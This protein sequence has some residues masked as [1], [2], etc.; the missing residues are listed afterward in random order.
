MAEIPCVAN[1]KFVPR[2][3]ALQLEASLELEKSVTK[4]HQQES[5]LVQRQAWLQPELAITAT[6]NQLRAPRD[7]HLTLEEL[8]RVSQPNRLYAIP[9]PTAQEAKA[10]GSSSGEQQSQ[11][12]SHFGLAASEELPDLSWDLALDPLLQTHY[13]GWGSRR[14]VKVKLQQDHQKPQAC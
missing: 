5:A 2:E 6:L 9:L 7:G 11:R 10:Q 1:G 4:Q 14:T 12:Q 8:I 3:S 13:R